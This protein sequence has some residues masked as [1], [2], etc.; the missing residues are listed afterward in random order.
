MNRF[1]FNDYFC[2]FS[3]R[4]QLAISGVLKGRLVARQ[5]PATVGGL[6]WNVGPGRWVFVA[7]SFG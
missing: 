5:K 7:V 1:I 2:M 3:I 6:G 4:L